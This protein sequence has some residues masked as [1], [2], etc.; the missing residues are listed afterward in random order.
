MFRKFAKSLSYLL[1]LAS[2]ATLVSGC[3]LRSTPAATTAKTFTIWAFDDEDVWKPIIKDA[4]KALKGY[5]IKYVKKKLDA[6][7]ENDA[8][9]SILSGQGPDI[10][11]MPNDWVYRHRDKLAEMPSSVIASSKIDIDHQ[12]VPAIKT[13]VDFDNKIYALSPTVDTLMVY[14]NSKLFD[15]ALE[16]FSAANRTVSADSDPV[17]ESKR[18]ALQR[19]SK[20]LGEVP[21][22]WNDFVETVK[23]ITK[24]NGAGFDRSGLAMG[25]TGNVT[26]ET[27]ILSALDLQN[28]TNMLSTDLKLANFNLPQNTAAGTNDYPARRALEFYT[29]FSNPASANYTWDSS[30]PSDIE[31]FATSKAAMMLGPDSL[32]WRLSQN[33]PDFR[34]KKAALP[35]IGS[36][37]DIISDYASFTAFTVPRASANSAAAWSIIYNLASGASSYDATVRVSTS[38]KKKDFAPTLADRLGSSNPGSFQNQTAKLWIK[39]RYPLDVDAIMREVIDN[40]VSSKLTS[41]ASLDSAAL[42]VTDLLK[43]ESW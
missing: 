31:A 4:A 34:F 16:E 1:M 32:S 12:F 21:G 10:W 7:Y 25:T 28:G 37:S 30:M 33:Y 14:Y 40:V 13:S 39:G 27:D 18:Q 8:L 19:A 11:A 9:N 17:R 24:K 3:S 26:Y 41:Q 29:S 23:L 43:K 20:L 15:A 22:T 35:Q 42:K 2:V 36:S 6:S 38:L 5:D